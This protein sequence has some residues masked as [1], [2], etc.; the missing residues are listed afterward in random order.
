MSNSDSL[1]LGKRWKQT[2]NERVSRGIKA[3]K[4]QS[5][6]DSSHSWRGNGLGVTRR[7]E[8]DDQFD[9]IT[10][11]GISKFEQSDLA[12]TAKYQAQRL[13]RGA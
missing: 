12:T 2:L 9:A 4:A 10:V 8:M 3:L 5:S 11:R 7:L 1:P 13:P 6:S